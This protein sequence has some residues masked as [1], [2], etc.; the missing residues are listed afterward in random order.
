MYTPFEA[1]Y[2]LIGGKEG[3]REAGRQGGREGG[4]EGGGEV[5]REG[6]RETGRQGGRETGRRE[7]ER[8]GGERE[9]E[10][11]E[12]EDFLFEVLFLGLEQYEIRSHACVAIPSYTHT[13]IPA[14]PIS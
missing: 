4:R 11:G 3:G 1:L 5:G 10:V 7:G 8:V 14:F 13:A 6:G 12:W 9:E 2:T